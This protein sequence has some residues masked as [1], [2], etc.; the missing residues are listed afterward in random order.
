MFGFVEETDTGRILATPG[1]AGAVGKI[2]AA[3][4]LDRA[5]GTGSPGGA[6][7]PGWLHCRTNRGSSWIT[8]HCRARVCQKSEVGDP[9]REAAGW[10][11]RRLMA[12]SKPAR[13]PQPSP[14]KREMLNI[15]AAMRPILRKAGTEA[16]YVGSP[17]HRLANSRIGRPTTRKWATTSKC[18]PDWTLETAT[19][20]LREAILAG[21]ASARWKNGFPCLA[22]HREGEVLY[23]ARL[24]N[25]GLGEYHAYPLEDI[26]EW[27]A[28]IKPQIEPI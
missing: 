1:Q 22:W 21:S 18:D 9:R 10:R 5:C 24:S 23:E 27:P 25:S 20:A 19:R 2:I 17:Y 16:R 3:R 11:R 15:T 14:K 4:S 8:I 26:R 28:N 6:L 12:L 7:Q 13:R